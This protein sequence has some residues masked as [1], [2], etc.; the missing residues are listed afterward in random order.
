VDVALLPARSIGRGEEDVMSW[1]VDPEQSWLGVRVRHLVIGRL[2]G[3][4]TRFE[5]PLLPG[6]PAP[7][8]GALCLRLE[9]A[10]L[11]TGVPERDAQLVGPGMLDA[12]RHPAIEFRAR[13]AAPAGDLLGV[14]TRV[15]GDLTIRDLTGSVTLEVE[16]LEAA[17]GPAG[18]FGDYVAIRGTVDRWRWQLR[19]GWPLFG[20]YVNVDARLLLVDA[21][22]FPSRW[23]APKPTKT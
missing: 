8:L 11:D 16:R 19:G 5:A 18:E 7:A 22:R 23:D 12:A 4:F 1:Y 3:R 13:Y 20:R 2:S 21:D 10:S 6:T 15:V 9:V 17:T 14:L